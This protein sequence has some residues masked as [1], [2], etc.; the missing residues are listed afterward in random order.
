MREA[1]A[2]FDEEQGVVV[3]QD[4]VR[5]AAGV[6]ASACR[7]ASVGAGRGSSATRGGARCAA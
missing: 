7:V 4:A 5:V 1:F 2:D 6:I 3:Q